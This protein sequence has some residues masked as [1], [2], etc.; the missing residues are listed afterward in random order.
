[1]STVT[2]K[3]TAIAT[4][5]VPDGSGCELRRNS[6]GKTIGTRLSFIG[7][8]S[9]STLRAE[10]KASG[11]KGKK[12]DAFVNASLTGDVA[13]AAWVRHDAILSGMRSAGAIPVQM[14]GNKA[15]TQFKTEY[16]IPVKA[17]EPTPVTPA[18]TLAEALVAAGKFATLAE[19]EAFL[20]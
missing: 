17:P 12:L 11:L 2:A 4:I 13:A 7:E 14:D 9:A 8:K 19:A 20:A 5:P 18:P 6:R 16:R 3:I 10:G 15:G 1:M